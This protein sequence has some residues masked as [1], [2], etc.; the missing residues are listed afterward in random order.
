MPKVRY[1][2]GCMTGTS[3]DGL[4]CALVKVTGAGLSMR[5][6]FITHLSAPLGKLRSPLRALAEQ[7]PMR[8]HAIAQLLNDFAHLH[9]RACEALWA[10]CN[11]PGRPHLLSVHG[12]T[13]YHAPPISWQLFAP[14]TLAA[15]TGCDV[16]SDLR[17]ANLA[18][19]G[20]G[21][22]LTPLA[23]G[24]LFPSTHPTAIINL[25]GFCNITFLPARSPARPL[26]PRTIRGCD[27]FP[28]NH[29]LNT[30]ARAHL[31]AQFDR[32]GAAA[33]RAWA[34]QQLLPPRALARIAKLFARPSARSLG[35]GDESTAAALRIATL[36]GVGATLA[37]VCDQLAT[38]LVTAAESY[39]ATRL[40]LA[41]GGALN[42]F[43]ASRTEVHARN[44]AIT[45]E[46]LPL[47]PQAREAAGWAVLGALHRD[48][49]PV[50]PPSI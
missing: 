4:D 28:C 40:L 29:I 17:A 26:D 27:L 2:I 7:T 33:A 1:I 36:H 21:A 14:Q 46:P 6:T 22:P 25:G 41:G 30:L 24:L 19:G 3:I 42:A 18:A 50:S 5:P 43:L 35:T 20:E 44:R 12:Q 9:A 10:Q 48:G 11:V 39:G 38:A 23:D 45:L 8:A 47:P 49:V 31:N 32:N 16:V 34:K 13:V 15:L 37:G